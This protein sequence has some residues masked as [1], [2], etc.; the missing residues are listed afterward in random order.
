ML[1]L[2]QDYL[3]HT[4][5]V[6]DPDGRMVWNMILTYQMYTPRFPSRFSIQVFHIFYVYM[7][8]HQLTKWHTWK[9]STYWTNCGRDICL[10][11]VGQLKKNLSSLI[12]WD[13]ALL[14]IYR[15]RIQKFAVF[16]PWHDDVIK[17]K[18]FLRYWPFM[19]GIHRWPV[20]SPHK[21]Q[22]CRALM[23]SLIC[24][25]INGW[26]NNREAGDLRRHHTHYDVT[27]MGEWTRCQPVRE[28][29]T[30]VRS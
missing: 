26:V 6:G 24:A 3:C 14:C 21:G 22:W 13:L 30:N 12:D 15:R 18:H 23:F 11:S 5:L 29:I 1:T 8:G 28:D 9:M 16:Y 2:P 7:C 10:E 25:W 17:W 27:V 4:R 19:Q 20:N